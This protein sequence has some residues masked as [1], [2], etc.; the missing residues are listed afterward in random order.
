M[1][2]HHHHH[3]VR[4]PHGILGADQ[5]D[6]L[7]QLS[8]DVA[9]FGVPWDAG[10]LSPLLSPGQRFGPEA[11]RRNNV[12]LF[13]CAAD[14][15]I[16]D[17][18]TGEERLTGMTMADIGDLDLMPSLG[19][20]ENFRR[21]TEVSRMV[22]AKGALPIAVGGDHSISFPA[23]RGAFEHLNEVDIVHFDSHADFEDEIGGSRLTHGSNL[24]RLSELPNVRHISA[25][26]LRHV[27]RE[28]YDPMLQYG[29]GF[30]SARQLMREGPAETVR[31][32]VPKA[33]NIYVSIDIDVLDGALVPGTC[34]PEPGGISYN[35]LIEA[36]SEVAK[37]G[38]IVGIDIVEINPMNDIGSGY[39]MAARTSSW[40]LFE[41]LAAIREALR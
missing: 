6:D 11:L 39:S 31:R 19:A 21:I 1:S 3:L 5:V 15:R 27:W 18:E 29:V 16:I 7:D 36:L 10:S 30:A 4:H 20:E 13:G 17:L 35:D 2:G 25:L 23:G 34:L 28:T 24:R 14:A 38:R 9:F 37:K 41:F 32:V 26:G 22:A 8:A 33:K 40:V 12:T